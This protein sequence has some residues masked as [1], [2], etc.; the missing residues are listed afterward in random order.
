MAQATAPILNSTKAA[1]G[2]RAEHVRSARVVQTSTCSA[3]AKSVIYLDPEIPD[4][5]L[6]LGMTEQS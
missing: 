2:G 5:A 3:I 1:V 4:R 6:E